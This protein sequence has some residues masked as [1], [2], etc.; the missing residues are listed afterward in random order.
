MEMRK[1]NKS[2]QKAVFKLNKEKIQSELYGGFWEIGREPKNVFQMNGEFIN[3][4]DAKSLVTEK[5][6]SKWNKYNFI[7]EK[8]EKV[9][10]LFNS[11]TNNLMFMLKEVKEIIVDNINSI[12]KIRLI[13]PDLY[14]FLKK[15]EFIVDDDFDEVKDAI[16]RIQNNPVFSDYFELIINPT[17]DCNLRCWYCYEHHQKRSSVNEEIMKS[18]MCFIKNKVESRELNEILISFF[19]GEPLLKFNEVIW[20]LINFT[21]KI[22]TENKKKIYV[23]FMTNAVLLSSKIID[24]LYDAGLCCTFQVP[25]DG[26]EEHHNKTKKYVN[27]KGTFDKIIGNVMYAL[28]KGNRFIIRCNYTSENLHSFGELISIFN[29]YASECINQGQ[30]TFSY[31]KVWQEQDTEEMK[32]EVNKLEEKTNLIDLSFDICYADRNNSVVINYNGDIYN[33]T[34]R[35]FK[36]ENREGY[37]NRQGNII[38]NEKYYRRMDVKFSNK[39][40]QRCIILPICNVCSQVRLEYQNDEIQCMRFATEEDKIKILMKKIQ[41]VTDC[42]L[43]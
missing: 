16:N 36:P 12:G 38:F 15:K 19:G 11:S 7:A 13:H 5:I 10:T 4:R 40:C 30:L 43:E 21:Q 39:N 14:F 6:S 9:Y 27:G 24:R 33:C 3:T 1:I 18:I 26:S 29:E 22:C 37:L 35:D 32:I 31:H 2:E 8:D 23:S 42:N 25:F 17:L 34:A 28:S 20:P 41:K